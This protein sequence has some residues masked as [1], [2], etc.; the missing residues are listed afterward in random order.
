MEKDRQRPLSVKWA[1]KAAAEFLKLEAGLSAGAAAIAFDLTRTPDQE[2]S[3]PRSKSHHSY[4]CAKRYKNTL[5]T[6]GRIIGGMDELERSGLIN[7]VQRLPGNRSAGWQSYSQAKP[8]L[9]ELVSQAIVYE[10][11]GII[12]PRET[13]ILRDVDRKLIDYQETGNTRTMRKNIAA[14]NEAIMG[15]QIGGCEVAAMARYFNQTMQRGGRWIAQ[16]NSWQNAPRQSRAD[17]TIGGE[18]TAELDYKTLHPAILYSMA[19]AALPE[20]SYALTGWPR[21]LVKLALLVTINAKNRYAAI[22][23]IAHSD[24]RKWDRDEGGNPI[25]FTH[26]RELMQV[27]AEPGS[28]EAEI[29]AKQLVDHMSKLHAPIAHFFGK[30]MGA[31]LMAIDSRMA[32][33]IMME[34][35]SQGITVLPVHDSFLV[36]ASKVNELE[37]AMM[38]AAYIEG[39]RAL[40][41]ERKTAPTPF[42]PKQLYLL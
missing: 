11:L 17:V 19:G 24:G 7:H 34:L 9:V 5:W 18:T 23:A 14:Q 33:V 10:P 8:E 22:G 42:S 13:V 4:L 32:D 3:Y 35:L 28:A 37:A 25:A 12:P 39:I 27:L 31:K 20:D 21:D 16:G 1:S 30:D 26:D 29:L 40:K 2:V 6:P 36:Q 38:K 41:V 15:T